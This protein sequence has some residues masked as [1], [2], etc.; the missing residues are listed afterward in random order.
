[1]GLSSHALPVRNALR[2]R[3]PEDDSTYMTLQCGSAYAGG[4]PCRRLA[5]MK[6]EN[7]HAICRAHFIRI[8]LED[9]APFACSICGAC[10]KL[11]DEI[12]AAFHEA[13]APNRRD[14]VDVHA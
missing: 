6:C 3:A 7:G 11:T 5:I 1:M 4:K 9:P 12:L 2:A 8:G 13:G 10:C 14:A